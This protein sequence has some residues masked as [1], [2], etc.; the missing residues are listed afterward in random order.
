MKHYDRRH[1]LLAACLSGLAGFVDALAFISL[2]GVFVSF[3][4]GNSTRL[5]VALVD[6]AGGHVAL[7][8]SIIALFVLGV[9]LGTLL[10]NRAGNR[11]IVTGV[12]LVALLLGA[13]ALAHDLGYLFLPIALTA[14]AMGA[15]NTIFARDGEVTIGLT[16]MTGM[17][18]KTGQ[19]LANALLGGP[20]WAWLRYVSLWL[21]LILGAMLG[22]AAYGSIGLDGLWIAAG[23]AV[24]LIPAAS[25][26]TP[27]KDPANG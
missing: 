18:V 1:I 10:N 16:Y 11:R 19:H 12:A 25:R 4:S 22:A 3:M 26:L 5:A 8:F 9:F 14:M 27:D 23:W 20:K 2:G 24:C 21:G 17:L 7:V 13:G 15:E 6:G